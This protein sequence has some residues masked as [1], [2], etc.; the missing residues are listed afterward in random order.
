MDS[1]CDKS[2]PINYDFVFIFSSIDLPDLFTLCTQHT[3]INAM[4][5]GMQ[6]GENFD[7]KDV[8]EKKP[9]NKRRRWLRRRRRQQRQP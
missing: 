4:P 6:N 2:E 3:I 5:I 7:G 9:T 8:A 1:R